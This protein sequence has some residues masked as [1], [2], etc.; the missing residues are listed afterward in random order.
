MPSVR[1]VEQEISSGLDLMI[2]A[3][4]NPD[5]FG[6]G[7]ERLLDGLEASLAKS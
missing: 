1:S 5:R 2:R 4:R 3:F 6:R 7:L